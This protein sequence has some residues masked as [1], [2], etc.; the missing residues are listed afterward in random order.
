MIIGYRR[1]REQSWLLN[2]MT[3]RDLVRAYFTYPAIQIYIALFVASAVVAVATAEAVLPLLAAAVAA[4]LLYPLVWYALHRWVLHGSWPYKTPYTAALWKRVHFDHHQHPNDLAV[5]FGGLHTTLP[6]I[7]LATVP[8]GL[9]IGGLPGAAAAL[10]GGLAM[11]CF[12]EFCHCIQ[13]LAYTPKWAFLRRIKRLHL[14][15]H[16]HN[17][18]GNYGITNY[19]WDRL[20]STYYEKPAQVPRSP[21][22]RNLGYQGEAAERYPWVA[23]LTEAQRRTE[24]RDRGDLAEDAGRG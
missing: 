8:V 1:W 3:L 22:V 16:F 20:L 5:L 13:H 15:H 7:V 23:E 4:C 14:A 24:T 17:E 6:T 12:Y 11:T 10:A 2:R 19:A 18:N 9:L 21:T